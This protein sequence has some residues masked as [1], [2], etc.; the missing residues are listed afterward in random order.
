MNIIQS[1]N[2]YTNKSKRDGQVP[3]M[4]VN[5][6]SEGSA[7]SCISWFTS[8]ANNESSAHF[9]VTKEG[10][11]HQFVTIEEMAWANG[12]TVDDIKLSKSA[13]IKSKPGIN[14]NKYTISIEHEGI[15][16]KTSGAL[17]EKQLSATIELHAYIIAYLKKKYDLNF[18]VDEEHIIGHNKVNPRTRP[19]CPGKLFPFKEIINGLKK[20]HWAEEVMKQ[21][22]NNFGL[23]IHE[24]RFDDNITRGE[25][26]ALVLQLAK[27]FKL[28]TDNK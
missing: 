8:P 25:T 13:I 22:V 12:L 10:V 14:P 18:I 28:Y 26:M 24:K 21:L 2:N 27:A 9:L 6:I 17:T 16:A 7:N 11:I 23:E 4:I 15:F 5:H 3:F 1:G 19:N 20:D